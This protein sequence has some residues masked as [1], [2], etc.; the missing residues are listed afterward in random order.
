MSLDEWFP[1]FRRFILSSFSVTISSQNNGC[2]AFSVS[3]SVRLLYSRHD[4]AMIRRNVGYYLSND[5]ASQP[6]R[7]ESSTIPLWEPYNSHQ[8]ACSVFS[9]SP[10]L[11]LLSRVKLLCATSWFCCLISVSIHSGRAGRYCISRH[12]LFGH[13]CLRL[14]NNCRHL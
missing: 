11:A 4:I 3:C 12:A 1:T 8:F 7:P 2:T 6:S 13:L 5:T 9:V 10:I 14:D